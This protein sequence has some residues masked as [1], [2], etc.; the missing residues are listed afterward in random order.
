M[1]ERTGMGSTF[2]PGKPR[3]GLGGRAGSPSTGGKRWGGWAQPG[4]VAGLGRPELTIEEAGLGSGVAFGV[5][6]PS[7]AQLLAV[8][9]V[10]EPG[11]RVEAVPAGRDVC[12]AQAPCLHCLGHPLRQCNSTATCRVPTVCLA[13]DSGQRCKMKQTDP[14][15]KA[16]QAR[17][18]LRNS[19]KRSE[20]EG[21]IQ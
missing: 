11:A 20:D 14:K 13:Q 17:C 12:S 2:T 5:A 7:P 16:H 21:F 1:S 6:I 4:A 3:C 8:E 9:E 10:P 18:E 15:L 19:Q